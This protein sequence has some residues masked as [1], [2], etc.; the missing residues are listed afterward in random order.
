MPGWHGPTSR[1]I[2]ILASGQTVSIYH[3][4][5]LKDWS[6]ASQFGEGEGAHI[7]VWECPDL[8][9]LPVD[10]DP[11]TTRES[12]GRTFPSRTDVVFTSVG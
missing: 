6:F 12:A 4:P 11:S 9:E 2:L 1:W 7:G 3:S 5:N 10:G 8:F